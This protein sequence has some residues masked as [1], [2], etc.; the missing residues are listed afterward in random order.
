MPSTVIDDSMSTKTSSIKN[1]RDSANS[2]VD[3]LID[4]DGYQIPRKTRK[5]KTNHCA[6]NASSIATGNRFDALTNQTVTIP[7][8][9]AKLC[10]INVILEG[11]SYTYSALKKNYPT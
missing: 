5:R 8:P 2:T 7:K 11:A 3:S 1:T 4:L 6:T 9:K 10:P